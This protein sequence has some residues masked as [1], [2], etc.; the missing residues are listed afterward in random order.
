MMV[1][2]NEQFKKVSIRVGQIKTL[3]VSEPCTNSITLLSK[4]AQTCDWSG[5][6]FKL[7]LKSTSTSKFHRI[8][9]SHIQLYTLY[10]VESYITVCCRELFLLSA[11]CEIQ[12][13]CLSFWNS[14]KECRLILLWPA[15][16]MKPLWSLSSAAGKCIHWT[17]NF[18]GPYAQVMFI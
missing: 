3:E 16:F 5:F 18:M 1:D 8:S 6:I 2:C 13:W 11:K 15:V 17:S 14:T 12:T 4:H 9:D 7:C 10:P